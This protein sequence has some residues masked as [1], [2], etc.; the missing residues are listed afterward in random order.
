MKEGRDG[1]IELTRSHM[2][3]LADKLTQVRY[4]VPKG[5]ASRGKHARHHAGT[6]TSQSVSKYLTTGIVCPSTFDVETKLR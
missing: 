5:K 2:D 1:K 4:S 3:Y 6:E